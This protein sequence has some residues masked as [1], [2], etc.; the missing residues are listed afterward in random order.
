VRIVA[1]APPARRPTAEDERRARVVQLAVED[2]SVTDR[3]AFDVDQWVLGAVQ[4]RNGGRERDGV[5]E[6]EGLAGLVE[7]DRGASRLVPVSAAV[8]VAPPLPLPFP[9]LPA[10][11]G[12]ET[13]STTARTTP[14]RV[15]NRV[16]MRYSLRGRRCGRWLGVPIGCGDRA[17]PHELSARPSPTRD[18]SIRCCEPERECSRGGRLQRRRFPWNPH[19]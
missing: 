4:P 15:W 14:A 1:D 7:R 19:G 18:P 17:L 6:R 12:A 13:A 9:P 3:P 2:R 16:L 5:P 10:S 8:A 11:A